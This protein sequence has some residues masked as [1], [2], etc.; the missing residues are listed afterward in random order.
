MAKTAYAISTPLGF[1]HSFN[2][3]HQVVS[4][5]DDITQAQLFFSLDDVEEYL[6]EYADVGY[7]LQSTDYTLQTIAVEDVDGEDE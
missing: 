1:V 7:G 3:E 6:Q 5:T 4:L 2:E